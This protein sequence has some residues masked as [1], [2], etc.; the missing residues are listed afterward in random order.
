[1]EAPDEM[2]MNMACVALSVCRLLSAVWL[3]LYLLLPAKPCPGP[4]IPDEPEASVP[5]STGRWDGYLTSCLLEAWLLCSLRLCARATLLNLSRH[6][7]DCTALP[8]R[9]PDRGSQW[10][11]TTSENTCACMSP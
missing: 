10:F 5:Q 6:A 9:R 2:M 8:S 3:R 1:M 4:S 7:N 11:P